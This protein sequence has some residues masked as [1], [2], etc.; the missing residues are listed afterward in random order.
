MTACP[1]GLT[2]LLEAAR[3]AALPEAVETLGQWRKRLEDW[4]G[5]APNEHRDATW[6]FLWE[7]FRE[8]GTQPAEKI[9]GASSEL[10]F[11]LGACRLVYADRWIFAQPCDVV[12]R[13]LPLVQ[14]AATALESLGGDAAGCVRLAIIDAASTAV[15]ENVRNRG[16]A[17]DVVVGGARWEW[18]SGALL[19]GGLLRV[20]LPNLDGAGAKTFEALRSLLPTAGDPG[21]CWQLERHVADQLSP[22]TWTHLTADLQRLWWERVDRNQIADGAAMLRFYPPARRDTAWFDRARNGLI[23]EFSEEELFTERIEAWCDCLAGF[24]PACSDGAR[25]ML[26]ALRAYRPSRHNPRCRGLVLDRAWAS[27]ERR[28]TDLALL[29]SLVWHER[30]LL[31]E[32]GPRREADE[33]WETTR[34]RVQTQRNGDLALRLVQS[35]REITEGVDSWNAGERVGW[36][37][38]TV[39]VLRKSSILRRAAWEP[40][41]WWPTGRAADECE[42]VVVGL[43]KGAGDQGRL[44]KLCGH[45]SPTVARRARAVSALVSGDDGSAIVDLD[46]WKRGGN[47]ISE[48]LVRLRGISGRS[49]DGRTWL[50]D[51]MVEELIHGSI[52]RVEGE[53]CRDYDSQWAHEEERLVTRLFTSLEDEFVKARA[54]LRDAVAHHLGAPVDIQLTYRETTKQEEGAPGLGTDRFSVDLAVLLRVVADGIVEAE[55]ASFVQCKKL[56]KKNEGAWQPSLKI[57]PA[58]LDDIISQTHAS[59]YLALAPALGREECWVLPACLVRSMLSAGGFKGAVSRHIVARGARSLA[60]WLTYDVIGLWVGDEDTRITSKAKGDKPG[61][62]PRRLLTITITTGQGPG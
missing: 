4:V 39:E 7:R 24:D 55:R 33:R 5:C 20:R 44:K 9:A 46:P 23:R 35:L 16:D 52:R 36:R 21:S 11:L 56:E 3:R 60:H 14:A 34:A 8:L 51:R 13:L 62:A 6:G 40:F 19:V 1:D 32:G 43:V 53:F 28:P 54:L 29:M 48:T 58:Q 59:F 57:N 17:F 2:P 37:M 26:E 49:S 50:G 22:D 12:S 25:A 15:N 41:L 47:P 45:V 42:M 31:E 18:D 27:W 10:V 30:V 38:A 61:R